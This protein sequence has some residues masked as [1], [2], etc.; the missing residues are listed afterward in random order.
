[1][2][3]VIHH[4]TAW[5]AAC[6]KYGLYSI[7]T[8]KSWPVFASFSEPAADADNQPTTVAMVTV[9]Q[10]AKFLSVCPPERLGQLNGHTK[11]ALET[12]LKLADKKP[13]EASPSSG[14]VMAITDG[15]AVILSGFSKPFSL[16]QTVEMNGESYTITALG[17]DPI[18][19][20]EGVVEYKD[21]LPPDND[22]AFIPGIQQLPVDPSKLDEKKSK[23]ADLGDPTEHVLD[24]ERS[25]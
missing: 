25:V 15:S 3:L 13:V 21:E 11:I 24:V 12:A 7:A 5:K 1:M 22:L 4:E 14:S 20:V 10:A 19:G 2:V 8:P 6:Q 18:T 16:G 9:D 23:V 17:P